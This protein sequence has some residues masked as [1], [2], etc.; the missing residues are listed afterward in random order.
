MLCG[1]C[2]GW[3]GRV[4]PGAGELR[5]GAQTGR[6]QP[7]RAPQPRLR[8]SCRPSPPS[9]PLFSTA[10]P[11]RLAGHGGRPS[12]VPTCTCRHPPGM[13][14]DPGPPAAERRGPPA[15]TQRRPA[16]PP[17]PEAASPAAPC[18]QAGLRGVGEGGGG[19]GGSCMRAWVRLCACVVPN[20]GREGGCATST[21]KHRK[22]LRGPGHRKGPQPPPQVGEGSS[23][24]CAAR[25][26]SGRTLTA[27]VGRRPLPARLP[28]RHAD[29]VAD[30]ARGQAREALPLQ[31]LPQA[32][33]HGGGQLLALLPGGRCGSQGRRRGAGGPAGITRVQ[34]WRAPGWA[35]LWAAEA[36]RKQH[37]VARKQL[38]AG[39]S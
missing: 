13:R 12:P 11:W 35:L 16:E 37:S 6:G 30:A 22:L 2:G 10:S 39:A 19:E 18:M 3:G 33:Q 7:A 5:P 9:A 1:V 36:G 4:R 14:L 24:P 8:P 21:H 20:L 26:V 25:A 27:A 34:E 31:Q 38:Q 23:G 32:R 17:P 29:K 15:G 28:Q